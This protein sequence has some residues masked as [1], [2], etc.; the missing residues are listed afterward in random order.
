MFSS[1][2]AKM[3]GCKRNIENILSSAQM[4]TAQV[5]EHQPWMDAAKYLFIPPAV[6]QGATKGVFS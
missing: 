5:N 2:C 1:A 6:G 4:Q 3:Y